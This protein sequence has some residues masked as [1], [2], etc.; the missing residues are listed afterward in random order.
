MKKISFILSFL[1]L[2]GSFVKAQIPS[3]PQNIDQFIKQEYNK[4]A[5]KKWEGDFMSFKNTYLNYPFNTKIKAYSTPNNTTYC[6]DAG[7]ESGGLNPADWNFYYG[8]FQGNQP[9]LCNNTATNNMDMSPPHFWTT[10]LNMPTAFGMN[11]EMPLTCMSCAG[12]PAPTD[13][14]HFRIENTGNDLVVGSLLPK[15]YSGNSS[16]R[17]GNA[18]I[19]CGIEKIEKVFTVTSATTN[20]SFWYAIVMGNPSLTDHDPNTIPSFIVQVKDLTSGS[21]ILYNNL[22]N[23]SSGLNFIS[24]ADLFLSRT[25]SYT[26]ACN[27]VNTQMIAY[28]PWTFLQIDLSTLIGKT[29]SVEIITRD[30]SHCGHFSYAYLD[31]FCS[32]SN[33]TNPTG[34]IG[35]GEADSCDLPGKICVNYT[36]P[37]DG[38]N[39]G[40]TQLTLNFLQNGIAV[41]TPLVSPT[42]ST[43]GT[44]CFNLTTANTPATDFDYTITG[45]FNFGGSSLPSQYIGTAPDGVTAGQNN[46]YLIHCKANPPSCNTCPEVLKSLSLT[47]GT[48]TTGPGYNLQSTQ[49]NF[50]NITNLQQVQISIADIAYSWDKEGCKNCK[51]EA[52]GRGCLFPQSNT[53]TIGSLVWDNVHNSAVPPAANA[54]ECPGELIWGLGSVL[55]PGTYSVPLNISLLLPTVP[56][57]CNLHL[58]KLCLKVTFKDVNCNT[59]D[60]IICISTNDCCKGG[61]WKS[62]QITWPKT[63]NNTQK[64]KQA[65]PGTITPVPSD[66]NV[67]NVDC[68]NQQRPYVLQCN[69]AY[70]FNAV[71]VCGDQTCTKKITYQVTGAASASGTLPATFTPTQSGTYQIAYYAWCGDKICDSCKFSV[72]V[73]CDGS[74]S[75]CSCNFNSI[76]TGA[77]L[78]RDVTCGQS[79]TYAI[80]NI[81]LTLNP[82]FLCVNTDGS[83]CPTPGSFTVTLKNLT[84]NVVTTL[85]PPNYSYTYLAAG[86]YLYTLSG[87]CGGNTCNCS[88]TVIIPSGSKSNGGK[89]TKAD[90]GK[91]VIPNSQADNTINSFTANVPK[92]AAVNINKTLTITVASTGKTTEKG[93]PIIDG[94]MVVGTIT[95]E[96]KP[97]AKAIIKILQAS[98]GDEGSATTDD[99]GNFIISLEHDTVHVIFINEREYGNIKIIQAETTDSSKPK[100][101]VKSI[102]ITPDTNRELPKTLTIIRSNESLAQS[103]FY[104]FTS[105]IYWVGDKCCYEITCESQ[106]NGR[107]YGTFLHTR[108]CIDFNE[109]FIVNPP[110]SNPTLYQLKIS[111]SLSNTSADNEIGSLD[112]FMKSG[113]FNI[114]KDFSNTDTD[115]NITIIK[116]GNYKIKDSKLQTFVSRNPL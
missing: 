91:E 21:P 23:L 60:T 65:I 10:G 73:D 29:V 26:N 14:V 59:C 68:S 86:S 103:S 50:S 16:L 28:K 13:Q 96:N 11:Y 34:F 38:K 77:G 8:N 5:G 107:I 47:T 31:D 94:N 81:P 22:V 24:S 87:T 95:N 61:Y 62:E 100:G 49:L 2:T 76:V 55:T 78:N 42:Y 70:T 57:C 44:Y 116:A 79:I 84:T 6:G 112:K 35:I 33:E 69:Q 7:F 12:T 43:N 30:C 1:L 98:T 48:I 27:T 64:Q 39:T 106:K 58:D 82:G 101:E 53:Q 111:N 115:G 4:G 40:T 56:G 88:F 110:T 36:V 18:A 9:F 102:K 92:T 89:L 66:Q 15:V 25:L 41:G 3:K 51:T 67:I 72:I 46:D 19:N 97:V 80:S 109:A 85:A 105:A 54:N 90:A 74:V 113:E 37:T 108:D 20:F 104:C 17:L 52:I 32:K 63:L 93:E 99:N 71:Y 83:E 75:N 114:A 45:T